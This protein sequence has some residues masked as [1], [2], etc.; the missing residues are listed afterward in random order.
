MLIKKSYLIYCIYLSGIGQYL[1]GS[2]LTSPWCVL[3]TFSWL[4]LRSLHD[5]YAYFSKCVSTSQTCSPTLNIH[6][7]LSSSVQSVPLEI[8]LERALGNIHELS[9]SLHS[10]TLCVSTI[11]TSGDSPRTFIGKYPYVYFQSSHV[12]LKRSFD[13]IEGLA[14]KRFFFTRKHSLSRLP[15]RFGLS[16]ISLGA[17][18]FISRLQTVSAVS[19]LPL[20]R[21]LNFCH[22]PSP[23]WEI[24]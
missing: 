24:G 14:T 8:P 12:S 10:R 1:W 13:C 11:S 18:N 4:S 2:L 23:T 20:G 22:L 3:Y 7:V 6:E 16:P 19:H 15:L 21:C 9:L 17:K 5:K